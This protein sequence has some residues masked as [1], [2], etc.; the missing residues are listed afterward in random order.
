MLDFLRDSGKLSERKARLFAVACCR[1]IWH[2]LHHEDVLNGVEVVERFADGQASLE[3][4]REA[5]ELAMWAGDDATYRG[6]RDAAVAWAV[7]AA[8]R[9]ERFAAASGVLYEIRMAFADA[10]AEERVK[11]FA[12]AGLLRD[13]VGSPP[14]RP[15]V[16]PSVRTWHGGTVFR[17][18]QTVYE[19]R[20]LPS[21]NLD[22]H[23]L[24]VLA[25]A[26]EEA[27]CTDAEILGHLRGPGPHTRGCHAVDVVLGK[28]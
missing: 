19:Q 5:D 18:A 12:Q 7:A 8:A 22:R 11:R 24:A 10:Q 4:L 23:R 16:P 2:L 6:M 3:E 27:G 14:F 26:L 17:L 20:E 15:V 28:T 13:I 1:R 21:G 25:D 9:R